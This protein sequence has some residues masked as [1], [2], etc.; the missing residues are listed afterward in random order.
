[1][2]SVWYFHNTI[3][4]TT[5]KLTSTRLS[6]KRGGGDIVAALMADGHSIL[7]AIAD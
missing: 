1:M 2:I 4:P 5:G 6:F 3:H 7:R